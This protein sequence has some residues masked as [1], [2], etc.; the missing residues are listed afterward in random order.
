MCITILWMSS[1]AINHFLL[2][3]RLLLAHIAATF[4]EKLKDSQRNSS[5]WQISAKTS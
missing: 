2:G 5:S 4:G 1:L 3:N